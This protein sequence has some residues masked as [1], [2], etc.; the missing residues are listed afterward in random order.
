M[1]AVAPVNYTTTCYP[2]ADVAPVHY[3]RVLT[4]KEYAGLL[5]ICTGSE[6]AGGQ[7]PRLLGCVQCAD[8]TCCVQGESRREMSNICSKCTMCQVQQL[9][10]PHFTDTQVVWPKP[11]KVMESG[12]EHSLCIKTQTPAY[13]N[14]LS[15]WTLHHGT[16]PGIEV[17]GAKPPVDVSISSL[18]RG[19][20]TRLMHL[21]RKN[22]NTVKDSFIF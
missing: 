6:A 16:M 4:C 19:Q 14:S 11:E 3:I 22:P 1:G 13:P 2:H 17:W 9:L 10:L 18:T 5:C 15:Q 12:F 7:R 20:E 21:F 8:P